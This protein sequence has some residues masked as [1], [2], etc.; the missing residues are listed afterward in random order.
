MAPRSD[1]PFSERGLRR[2]WVVAVLFGLVS[3]LVIAG[4]AVLVADSGT[5]VGQAAPAAT[6]L[7]PVPAPAGSGAPVVVVVGDSI[8]EQGEDELVAA[9]GEEWDLVV[10]GRSGWTAGDMV[11][12]ARQLGVL[13]PTQVIVNL[14]TNDVL[15]GNRTGAA[16]DDLE[17]IIA[18][19][20]GA[21]CLHLVTIADEI[22]WADVDRS[23]GAV[24]LNDAIRGIVG[25]DPRVHLIDWAEQVRA[26]GGRTEELL[27][28]TV[29]PTVVGHELLADAYG[30][31]LRDCPT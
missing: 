31:A 3:A 2:V 15:Q 17:E 25:T 13:E 27:H 8:T 30:A 19:F 1:P 10:D 4:V 5:G 29:H 16:V 24:E 12:P 23:A 22:V 6:V 20:P 28:D 26:D 11:P 18:A 14:G 9:L 21:S 7:G